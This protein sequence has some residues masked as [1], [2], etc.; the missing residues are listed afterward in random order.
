M[1]YIQH[2]S[3]Q[4]LHLT[5]EIEGRLNHP[6]CG[7]TFEHYRAS[8]NVPLGN[9]CKMCNKRLENKNFNKKNL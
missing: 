5:F 4:K 2:K 3:G 9:S 1:R 7:R 8:F 6:I